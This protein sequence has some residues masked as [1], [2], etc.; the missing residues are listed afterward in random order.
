M[1]VIT[2]DSSPKY[3]AALLALQE[4]LADF[5]TKSQEELTTILVTSFGENF[6]LNALLVL[7]GE[8]QTGQLSSL[9]TVETV[10]AAELD[11]ATG[12]YY[13][14][15][16]ILYLSE[17]YFTTTSTEDLTST[18]LQ[19]LGYGIDERINLEDAPGDEGA[20]WAR[21][22]EGESLSNQQLA[23]LKAVDNFRTPTINGQVVG[24]EVSTDSTTDDPSDPSTDIEG[25]S[26][27][28]SKGRDRF[29]GTA[30][31]DEMMAGGGKDRLVGGDG[32]DTMDGGGGKDN[33]KG[34]DGNDTLLGG[35]GSDKLNGGNGDDLINGGK[36]KDKSKGGKGA[37]Q[38]IYEKMGDKGDLILDFDVAEDVIDLSELLSDLGLES[39]KFS[40]LVDNVI[41]LGSSRKGTQISIDA[42]GL[43]GRG[44]AKKFIFLR[45]VDAAD[46]SR[47]NFE[48]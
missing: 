12:A 43:D 45:K 2:A 19:H 11:D 34:G 16:N 33:I 17:E 7:A 32:D 25:E 15:D 29:K 47:T 46:L 13:A 38:F 48:L 24:V 27:T 18:L 22:V 31:N 9:P 8:L 26:F 5:A 6:D 1:P 21:L 40:D 36:G 41:S 35:G 44:K 10:P 30:G 4:T 42:D 23:E 14:F 20:I 37:D 39:S 28:G 3:G